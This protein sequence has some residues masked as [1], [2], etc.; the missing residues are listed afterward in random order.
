MKASIASTES[1]TGY[2]II[3]RDSELLSVII[4]HTIQ[5]VIKPT[6]YVAISVLSQIDIKEG[7]FG[8]SSN[9]YS[10]V[11]L[12]VT[13]ITIF[14]LSMVPRFKKWLGWDMM[15]LLD[16]SN[17]V[18]MVTILLNPL[19][20]SMYRVK[21]WIFFWMVLGTVVKF[22]LYGIQMNIF[23]SMVN[24]L[25]KEK[26]RPVVM[27]LANIASY[28]IPGLVVY[29]ISASISLWLTSKPLKAIFR[30]FSYFL[31]FLF[32]SFALYINHLVY[33]FA[34]EKDSDPAQEDQDQPELLNTVSHHKQL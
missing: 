19:V 15:R 3:Q 5:W 26:Y 10:V 33:I 32:L 12:I 22:V 29:F 14:F 1:L 30:Q 8:L 7:G 2:K 16:A 6:D 20:I 25:A 27:G 28:I 4:I 31:T 34:V 17:S 23:I 21:P 11:L 18:L 24:T 13:P 9:E